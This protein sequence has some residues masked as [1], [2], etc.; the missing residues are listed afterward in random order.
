MASG[1]D[2]EDVR[3]FVISHRGIPAPELFPRWIVPL[4]LIKG[5]GIFAYIRE[6]I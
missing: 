2:I 4:A 5:N 6:K 1:T 3:E